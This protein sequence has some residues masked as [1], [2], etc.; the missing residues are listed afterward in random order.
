MRLQRP[1]PALYAAFD[2]FP[3]AKGAATHID[4]FARRLFE[5]AGG[6]VLQ[7][8]G[9]GVMP[10]YQ[11][12]G[13]V[14]ILRFDAPIPN[15]LQR[16]MAYGRRL[17]LLIEEQ[18]GALRLCH[19]RDPWGGVPILRHARQGYRT[20]YEVNGLPSV[21]LPHSYPEIAPQTREKLRAAEDFCLRKA[22]RIVTP[23]QGIA[24]RLV[25]RGVPRERI[26]VIPNGADPDV[27]AGEAPAPWPY[28]LYFGAV[29]PWQ[30]LDT[31]L[32]AFARLLDFPG[33]RL[34]ICS[35]VHRRRTKFYRKLAER[36][37]LAGRVH[38]E[39]ALPRELL[40]PWRQHALLSVAPLSE[41][42]RNLEQ[43]CSPLKILESMAAGVPVVA[44]DLP[45]VRE[46]MVD[47]EHGRLVP[48]DRP[49]D[50][51]RAIRILLEYPELRRRMG[52]QARQHLQTHYTWDR[53]LAQLDAVY[54][55]LGL[56]PT[57]AEGD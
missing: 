55:E 51:A 10:A 6:G 12:E 37:G 52:E 42:E 2:L 16:A 27:G 49:A 19:F 1:P 35:S 15:F 28:I 23:A 32:R 36:L 56:I 38:W 34:V 26:S 57:P 9:D 5:R 17:D 22:D 25:E 11:R 30:G 24:D 46:L 31:L 21:E 45:S 54:R 29:Q 13:A 18:G 4:R 41:C 40:A 50:L 8:L 14:E 44:S 48:P 7:V 47:G 53:A 3:S 33:L 20:L 39:H 43:G